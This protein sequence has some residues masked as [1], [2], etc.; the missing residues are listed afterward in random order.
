VTAAKGIKGKLGVLHRSGFFQV[1][2]NGH[3]LYTFKLDNAKKGNTTGEGI[4]SFG[5][6]W[7]VIAVGSTTTNTN[8]M[9]TNTGTTTTSTNPYPGVPGY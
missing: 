1:T 6:T 4:V 7:H 3:P 2:L 8:T 9:P 5:G